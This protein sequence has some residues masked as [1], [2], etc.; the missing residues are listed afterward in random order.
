MGKALMVITPTF[1][2]LKELR[3]SEGGRYVGWACLQIPGGFGTSLTMTEGSSLE[4]GHTPK[5]TLPALMVRQEEALPG[6]PPSLKRK[7]KV[8]REELEKR[9][10]GNLIKNEK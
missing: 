3:V 7:K 6:N 1:F 5:P 4:A 2:I 10:L 9:R 8:M